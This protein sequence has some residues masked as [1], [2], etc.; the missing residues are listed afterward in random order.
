LP[1]PTSPDRRIVFGSHKGPG[2]LRPWAFAI[3]AAWVSAD[4]AA[5][6]HLGPVKKVENF[7]PDFCYVR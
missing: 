3:S 6:W 1:K 2:A 5:V 7:D 4:D